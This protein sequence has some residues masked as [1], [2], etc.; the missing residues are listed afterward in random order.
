MFADWCGRLINVDG[1]GATSTNLRSLG[2]TKCARPVFPHDD[3][4][5]FEPEV[6]IFQRARYRPA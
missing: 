4:A 5:P 2:H 1:P 3:E 6:E